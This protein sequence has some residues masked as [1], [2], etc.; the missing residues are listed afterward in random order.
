MSMMAVARISLGD[1]PRTE[2]MP[3]MD[4]IPIIG[5][6]QRQQ[7]LAQSHAPEFLAPLVSF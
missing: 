3:L 7:V 1:L 5:A 2:R 4:A 6:L